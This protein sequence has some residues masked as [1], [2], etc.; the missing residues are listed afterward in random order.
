[1]AFFTKTEGKIGIN[2]DNDNNISGN[3]LE[4]GGKKKKDF[5]NDRH[6][7]LPFYMKLF[8]SS[9][10]GMIVYDH[11]GQC[12]EANEVSA[13]IIGANR[14]QVLA[15]NYHQIE[16]WKKSGLLKTALAAVTENKEKS[17]AVDLTSTFGRSISMNFH[18]IP[19][20]IENQN[21]LYVVFDDI[22]ER[23]KAE[24]ALKESE[25][26]L[27]RAQRIAK[28]GSWHR[29][30]DTRSEFWS[31]ECFS[32]FGLKQEDYPGS[33]VP[34]S[35]CLSLCENPQEI[36]KVS[37][38]LA[39]KNDTYDFIYNTSPINGK[40]KNIHSYCEVERDNDGC[41]RKIFG[42]SRDITEQKK[43]ELALKESEKNLERAQRVAMTGS[44][45]H[46]IES[47][48]EIW[49][50][51]CFKLFGLDKKKFPDNEVSKS[52]CLSLLDDPQ[53]TKELA[54]DLANNNDNYDFFYKTI[55]INGEA[56]YI[57]SFCE[58][59]RDENGKL[60][61]LFG[62][63]QDI[64][65]IKRLEHQL[66]NAKEQAEA[67]NKAKSEF[68]SNMSHELRTPLQGIN[69]YSNLAVERFKSTKKA[70]FLDYFKEI[71]ASGRRLL[72]LLNDLLD[73]AKLESGK[74]DYY[75]KEVKLSFLIVNTILEMQGLAKEK[76][77]SI[78]FERAR[79]DDL[80]EIDQTKI[81]QVIRN[82]LSNAI[83]FS[84]V[85]NKIRIKLTKNEAGLIC[86]VIDNGVGIPKDELNS[87]FD[88]FI[89]SS[90]TKTGAGGTGLGLAICHEIIKA[91]GGKI[92]AENAIECGMIFNFRLPFKQDSK[93]RT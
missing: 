31:K 76:N 33:I 6:L 66:V 10:A 38:D 5:S 48:I 89:Q 17:R 60:V 11:S 86:N 7:S 68:L 75:F 4:D 52:V 21:F 74:A 92:W 20:L 25:Q 34:E 43:S 50:S 91:H 49:S 79:F 30:F 8:A 62:V 46:F 63:S 61:K 24:A 12:I 41:I 72:T 59:E 32:L 65:E 42:S 85:G 84:N 23:K 56:K 3:P 58:V 82:L 45:V 88:K 81:T 18:F 51:E 78:D 44:W 28:T 70:K 22:T 26:H 16:S 93:H 87:V 90:K 36:K 83:K 57:R 64:T 13:R 73:L 27:K 54:Y 47:G 53:T 2:L 14:N 71:S 35:V 55:P 29:N 39:E 37:I 40:V 15:Q 80:V 1:M 9:P 69:G 77:I 19:L 67:A